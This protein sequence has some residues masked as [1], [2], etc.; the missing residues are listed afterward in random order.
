MSL[1]SF[2][3]PT[4]LGRAVRERHLG[5]GVNHRRHRALRAQFADQP[6]CRGRDETE[7]ANLRKLLK[8]AY[9][10]AMDPF[11]RAQFRPTDCGFREAR[12]R[13]FPVNAGSGP[14]DDAERMER[15]MRGA[16]DETLGVDPFSI[17]AD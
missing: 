8:L 15:R 3:H 4:A 9:Q 6:L 5:E 1:M 2:Y 12:H 7:E 13:A 17:D 14:R 16:E 10:L 11:G